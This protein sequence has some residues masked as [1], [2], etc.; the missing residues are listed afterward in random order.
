[1]KWNN[2]I[3]NLLLLLIVIAAIV[4]SLIKPAGYLIWILESTPALILLIIVIATYNKFRFTT[5]SYIIIA[6]LPILMFIGAHYTYG[7]VPLFNW[8]KEHFHLHR[9]NYDRFGHFLKGLIAIVIRE[10]LLRKTPLT[11][12]AWLVGITLSI[13]VSIAGLY[14]IGEFIAAKLAK[15]TKLAKDFLGTQ[16]DVWDS[17]WDMSLCLIGS[18][19]TLLLLSKLHDRFL[20][21]LQE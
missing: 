14:E 4:W 15:G 20:N 12:G 5:L 17:Q 8:I 6:F 19:L 11:R 2:S 9:N 7:Q 13:S 21:H 18:I 3:V 10:I 1:M 16:G